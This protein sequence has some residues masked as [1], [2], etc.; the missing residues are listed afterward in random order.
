MLVLR[1]LGGLSLDNGG[2]PIVGAM[3]QRGRLAILAVLAIA[4]ERGISRDRLLAIFWPESD[5]ERARGSLKQATFQL[6]RDAAERELLLGT[7]EMRFNPDVIRSDVG[8]FEDALDAGNVEVA[9]SQYGGSFLE[10]I[11]LH[12][13][14]EFERWAD[15]ERDRLAA[16][17]RRGL[18]QLARSCAECGQLS[19][20]VE[21]WRTLSA[22]DPLS[23]SVTLSLMNALVDVGDTTAALRHARIYSALVYQ[24]LEAPPDPAVAALVLNLRR[25]SGA[26]RSVLP[27]SG[28]ST[29]TIVVADVTP[30]QRLQPAGGTGRPAGSGFR[31]ISLVGAA[32]VVLGAAVLGVNRIH[33][34]RHTAR[35]VVVVKQDP[36]SGPADGSLDALLRER[37]TDGVVSTSL[38]SPT[39]AT[40]AH[41]PA[42]PNRFTVLASY[43]ID[44]DS[45][46]L[47]A[48]LVPDEAYAPS[49][50]IVPVH[51]ARARAREAVEV[52]RTRMMAALASRLDPKLALWAYASV[53]PASFE[54]VRELR[55]GID[56]Y[57]AGEPDSLSLPHFRAAATLDSASATAHVWMAY[58]TGTRE[59]WAAADTKLSELERSGRRLGPWDRALLDVLLAQ[60]RGDLVTAYDAGAR[61]LKLVPGS[62]WGQLLAWDA[63]SVGRAG[64]AVRI[65]RALDPDRGW[66]DGF[67]WYWVALS[68]SYHILGDYRYQLIA[69]RQALRREPNNRRFIQ[70][71][72]SALAALGQVTE[73]KERCS[74]TLALRPPEGWGDFATCGQ[75]IVELWAHGHQ[76]EA[77]SLADRMVASYAVAP[78]RTASQRALDIAETYMDVRNYAAA[79]RTLQ[80]IR[81]EHP[82][83]PRF[84]LV[85]AQLDALGGNRDGVQ[86]NLAVLD[87]LGRANKPG[88]SEADASFRR[89]TLAAL[90]GDKVEAMNWIN[91]SFQQGFRLRSVLHW[92]FAFDK[93]RGYPPFDLLMRSVDRP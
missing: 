14:P 48:R 25:Q 47:S 27:T 20:A 16:R 40:R 32:V 74:S 36:A 91:R 31:R 86:E 1:T 51:A 65:L 13:S 81:S 50:P 49:T 52:L 5:A 70:L 21:W 4:R 9:V 12:D 24:E 19:D 62:E 39:P 83:D 35:V 67:D 23:A 34:D 75:G 8:A 7:T 53:L 44:G 55:L 60:N 42:F 78:D 92:L 15:A 30:N 73:V 64:E 28:T 69:A 17:Y 56:A 43:A 18:E 37:L 41:A 59:T 90:L 87:S 6:R 46:L 58:V 84:Y 88:V 3:N 93:M 85:S 76:R 26:A 33:D 10:G 71:E 45:M 22:S 79:G 38:I 11:H 66:L 54:G 80:T 29:A 82:T 77:G 2:R 72:L 61:L 89:A 57:A 63:F 68:L